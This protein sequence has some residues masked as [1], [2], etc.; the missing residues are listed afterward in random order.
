[1]QLGSLRGGQPGPPGR[2]A[3]RRR[4]PGDQE[5]ATS[6]GVGPQHCGAVGHNEKCQVMP[7]VTY[8]SNREH[9]FIDRELYLPRG[10]TDDPARCA[11]AGQAWFATNP[12]W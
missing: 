8:A 1:M 7:M 2:G 3:D 6:V 4:H 11:E 9:A 12:S 10:R 5:G